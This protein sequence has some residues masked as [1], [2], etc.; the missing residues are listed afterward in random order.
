MSTS[1]SLIL[2]H[3]DT[4]PSL[5]DDFYALIDPGPRHATSA[6]SYGQLTLPDVVLNLAQLFVLTLQLL[7]VDSVAL[8][9]GS[10]ALVV[11]VIDRTVDFGMEIMVVL[12]EFELTRG[13]SA[14]GSR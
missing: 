3:K 10:S 2:I 8:Y 9:L 5:V 11:E 13:V 6:S 14:E 4:K 1:T 7:L 12:E